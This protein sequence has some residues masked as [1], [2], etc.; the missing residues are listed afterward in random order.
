MRC[1]SVPILILQIR[2]R[3]YGTR[4]CT[5]LL[6]LFLNSAERKG[7]SCAWRPAL[8]VE[9]NWPSAATVG[10]VGSVQ[11]GLGGKGRGREA[12]AAHLAVSA[13]GD[14]G[15]EEIYAK[16][17]SQK[18]NKTRW[19]PVPAGSLQTAETFAT[20]SWD[21]EVP[22]TPGPGSPRLLP[23]SRNRAPAS[24]ARI[25]SPFRSCRRPPSPRVPIWASV[26]LSPPES[27]TVFLSLDSRCVRIGPV[28]SPLF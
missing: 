24:R 9:E 4:T 26:A 3:A 16:F 20:G 28:P 2:G 7:S 5:L 21:N 1:V 19:R 10:R 15:M 12:R 14:S 17:V 22:P 18:I 11:S 13:A 23:P 8:A 6:P 27:P 25:L